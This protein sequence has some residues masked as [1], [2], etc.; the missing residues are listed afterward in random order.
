M[1]L[2]YRS[3]VGQPKLDLTIVEIE[4]KLLFKG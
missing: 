1:S 3:E 4:M 2:S